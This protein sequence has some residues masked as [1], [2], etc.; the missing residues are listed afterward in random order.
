MKISV[1]WNRN[2]QSLPARNATA[3]RILR[4]ERC[5]SSAGSRRQHHS[6]ATVD[7]ALIDVTDSIGICDEH[8][9]RLKT[10]GHGLRRLAPTGEDDLR[11]EGLDLR[12]GHI[13]DPGVELVTRGG[14]FGLVDRHRRTAVGETRPLA[15]KYVHDLTFAEGG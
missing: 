4:A 3:S 13:R 6:D 14:S 15:E 1:G 5:S 12:R 8:L 10:S 9:L 7:Q 2:P 11:P